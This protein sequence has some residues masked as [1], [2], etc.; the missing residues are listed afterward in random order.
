MDHQAVVRSR[1]MVRAF[2]SSPLDSAVVDRIL[3]AARR[4]PSAG[5]TH[6]L[7]L[8]VLSGREQVDRY[9]D[10]TLHSERRADFPWPKLL[11]APVI[12][13]VVVDPAAYVDRYSQP[14]KATSGLG[15]S[16][17]DWPVP[18]W[19]V[20]GGAAIMAL[21]YAAVDEG[22]GALLFGLFEHEAAVGRRFAIP[23]GRRVVGA[24]ALGEP[25]GDDRPSRSAE[26]GRPSLP[27]IVHRGAW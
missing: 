26:R 22:L 5:N 3:D 14:D 25:A 21:L 15:E 24:V 16:A 20:D 1:R 18:F 11:D 7:D 23:D 4:A 12:V 17:D 13:L 8:V 10:T 9:W 19:F 27:E 2:E 6:G